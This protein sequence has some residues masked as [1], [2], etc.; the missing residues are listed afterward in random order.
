MRGEPPFD[1]SRFPPL[2]WGGARV[3]EDDIAFIADWIDD[4]CPDGD[5]LTNFNV[6]ARPVT[7][8]AR[9][10][11]RDIAEFAPCAEGV[12]ATVAREGAPRQR[13]DLDCMEPAQLDLLRRSFR[14]TLRSGR[15]AGRSSQL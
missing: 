1:G 12:N 7:A 9:V 3:S 8:E 6:N 5:H 14:R 15:L 4:G 11:V 2:L 13:I 10:A